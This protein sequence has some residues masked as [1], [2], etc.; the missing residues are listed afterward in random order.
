M[1]PK[2]K[3]GDPE[4]IVTNPKALDMSAASVLLAKRIG[5]TL[6]SLYP[7]WLWAIEVDERGGVTTIRSLRLSGRWGWLVKTVDIQ[8]DPRLKLIVKGAGEILERFGQ[9]RGRYDYARWADSQKRM[10]LTAFDVSDKSLRVRRAAR[11]QQL[12]QA[13][14]EGRVR[15]H[16]EDRQ[17]PTGTQRRIWVAPGRNHAGNN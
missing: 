3:H 14:K 8:D 11:D 6:E 13:V 9:P 12:T 2:D 5:D 4:G 1:N 10:G 17:T 15:L 16:V 7:G